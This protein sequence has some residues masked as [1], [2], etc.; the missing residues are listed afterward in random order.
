MPPLAKTLQDVRRRISQSAKRG[1]NEQNTKA[2]LIEPVLRALG[3]DTEDVDEVAREY[4]V[5]RREKPVDY[6]LLDMRTP[7]LFVEAKGLG[8]NLDDRKWAGQ[9]MGYAAVAG[10]EWIVLTD[11]NDYRIY[12]AHAPVH[13]DE[14][15]FR[16]VCVD[17]RDPLVEATL[18]LLA[19]DRM[20]ENRIEILWRAQFVDRQV[21]SALEQIFTNDDDML[22]VNYVASRA[23][24]LTA[25][26]IRASLHRCNATFDFPVPKDVDEVVVEKG[27]RKPKKP[28]KVQHSFIDVTVKQLIDAGL[29]HAPTELERE[30]KGKVLKARIEKDGRVTFD[31]ETHHSPSLAGAMARA[32]VIGRKTGGKL[33]ATNG[34]TFW[35]TK[36]GSGQLVMLAELRDRY[37]ANQAA[38]KTG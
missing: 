28:G 14:K 32:S 5:K 36:D 13:V 24:N 30:Y 23:N 33:P 25:E 1:L 20:K 10:V 4:H 8:Q 18:E 35:M 12:N 17:S 2:T 27:V 21:R 31:R 15:L 11:G 29:L 9:I 34:W 38:E 37:L 26:E 19:K 16:K 7:R 22:V 6:G 3:W